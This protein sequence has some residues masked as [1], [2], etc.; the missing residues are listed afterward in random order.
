MGSEEKPYFR[1][2]VLVVGLGISGR[3]AVEFLVQQGAKVTCVDSN[4]EI[5]SQDT[6]FKKWDLQGVR[7]QHEKECLVIEEFDLIVVSPGIPQTHPLYLRAAALNIE[8]IG[9]VELACRTLNQP[10]IGI[11]GTNGKTTVTLLTT[12]VLNTCGKRAVALGNVGRPLASELGQVGPGEIIV[13]ELS[14]YQLETMRSKKIDVGVILNVTPD[15]LDRYDSMGSYAKAKFHLKECV[16]PHGKLYVEEN[17]WSEYGDL[18]AGFPA[19]KYGYGSDCALYTDL[20][21]ILSQQ[22]VEFIL[23][24]EYRGRVS[25]NLENL[26]AAYALCREMGVSGKQFID[27]AQTFRKPPHRIEFVAKIGGVSYYDDS[28]GTNIDAVIRAVEGFSGKI[29]LIAGGVDKGASYVPWIK[30]F[31]GKVHYICAIGKAAEK[32]HQELSKDFRV[33]RFSSLERAVKGAATAA[34]DG[35]TILLSPGCASFDMFR[36]YAHRGEEF[37]RI[38]LEGMQQ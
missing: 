6:V 36:D 16:K 9:E 1:K 29:I 37:K 4:P 30:A 19:E 10:F 22:H 32:I 13:A 20:E 38:V 28:K 3:S 25:H 11:T 23:P 5:I 27:A 7:I 21:T 35:D 34:V 14:S 8:I 33:D 24:M 2:K 31:T 18:L 26:M 17:A 15:H 12:H